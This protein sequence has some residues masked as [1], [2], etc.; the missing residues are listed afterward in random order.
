M[1]F[2]KQTGGFYPRSI[3]YPTLPDDLIDVTDEQYSA[4]MNLGVGEKIDIINGALIII[5]PTAEE[6]AIINAPQPEV[7]GFIQAIK[8]QIGIVAAAS[9][10]GSALMFSALQIGEW[11]DASALIENALTLGQITT[12]QHASIKA[13]ALTFNIPLSLS[14]V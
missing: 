13:A 6:L 10:T 14:N 9:I 4:A 8:A 3:N 1:R 2:S 7:S 5:P 11:A 12:A